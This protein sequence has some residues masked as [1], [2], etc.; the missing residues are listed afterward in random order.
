MDRKIVESALDDLRSHVFPSPPED[1]DLA[2]WIMELLEL[3]GFYAGIATSVV[4]GSSPPALPKR[5]EL[6]SLRAWLKELR[7]A[8]EED[9]SIL[10]HC[11][12]YFQVLER[13]HDS[14]LTNTFGMRSK[15][16]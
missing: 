15:T 9:E 10:E 3:D 11:R 6:D 14:L 16:P 13:L 2:D 7:A 1:P 8:T 12:R 4:T 5:D